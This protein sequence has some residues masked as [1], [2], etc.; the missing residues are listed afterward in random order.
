MLRELESILA[1]IDSQVTGLSPEDL[2]RQF[3]QI[4]LDI[5]GQIQIDQPAGFS[6]IL[7]SLPVM[8]AAEIQESWTGS[9]GH[10]LMRQSVM[11]VKTV[12]S[13]YHAIARRPLGQ[14]NVLDFGCGWGRLIRLLYKY[15]PANRI[16]GVDPWDRS[17]EICRE[18]GVKANLSVSDYIPRSLPTPKDLKFNFIMAFSVFTH[19]SQKVT[20]ICGETLRDHLTDDGILAITVRPREYWGFVGQDPASP[21]SPEAIETLLSAHDQNG[22]A[23]SPHHREKIEGEVTYGDTSMT[24]DFIESNFEGLDIVGVESNEVDLLQIIVFLKKSGT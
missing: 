19:L 1:R 6:N 18:T 3:E 9:S 2:Q 20:R 12:V 5:L 23:F 22:F 14:G 4:P 15:V 16:Y 21:L 17:I 7:R 24:L 11:F 13:A 8:P 10:T